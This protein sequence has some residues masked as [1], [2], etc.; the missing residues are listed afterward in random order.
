MYI[1]VAPLEKLSSRGPAGWMSAG[2]NVHFGSPTRNTESQV[3]EAGCLRVAMYIS[4]SLLELM[5]GGIVF[6]DLA[7]AT[8]AEVRRFGWL[9]AWPAD[10]SVCWLVCCF[11]CLFGCWLY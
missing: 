10:C 7:R 9:D 8:L 4:V 5:F 6:D 3:H 2:F 11:G 1:S